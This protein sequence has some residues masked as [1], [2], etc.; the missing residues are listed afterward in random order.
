M[1]KKEHFFSKIPIVRIM[2]IY[3]ILVALTFAKLFASKANAQNI[4]LEVNNVRLK[5][6]LM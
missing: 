5:R 1:E 2:K 4:S 3:L 6:I